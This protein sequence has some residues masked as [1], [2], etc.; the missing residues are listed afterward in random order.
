M[1]LDTSCGAS[2]LSGLRA[3]PR[4]GLAAAPD[5]RSGRDHRKV[6]TSGTI[7]V[8]PWLTAA[9]IGKDGIAVLIHASNP[10]RQLAVPELRGMFAGTTTSWAQVG[11]TARPIQ[12]VAPDPTTGT[13]GYLSEVLTGGRLPSA[14]IYY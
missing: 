9:P 14:R 1:P 5:V 10:V 8:T 13:G 11:G 3:M 12:V 2:L 7:G 4:R 6:S